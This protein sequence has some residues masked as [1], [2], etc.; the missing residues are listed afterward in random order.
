MQAQ[1]DEGQLQ[2]LV[3]VEH[4]PVD[5]GRRHRIRWL[6]PSR[7]FTICLVLRLTWTC[8]VL[9]LTWTRSTYGSAG[10]PR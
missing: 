5:V 3:V 9:R 2:H 10:S 7:S 4:P 8:L 1:P 6:P